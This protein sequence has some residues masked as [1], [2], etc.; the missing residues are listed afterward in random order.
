MSEID[1]RSASGDVVGKATLDEALFGAQVNVPV[2]HQVVRAQLAAA[3]AGTR[4]TKRRGQVSGGGA[5]PWRQKG[6]GR[7]RQGSNRAPH[8]SGGGVVFGPQPRD[9]TMKVNKKMR[10]VALRS[11]LSDRARESRIAVVERF[12]FET[13]KTADAVDILSKL[14]VKGKSLV[15]IENVDMTVGKSFR[16]LPDVHVITVDQLNTYDIINADWLVFTA[17][18]LDLVGKSK[19]TADAAADAAGGDAE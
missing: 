15:V 13:P 9:F 3:R 1:V 6:T 16:N 10:A 8:W 2:M 18:A 17:K 4:A 7:A 19:E 12:V 5:K 14:G 11:A